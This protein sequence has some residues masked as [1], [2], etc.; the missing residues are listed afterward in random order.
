MA[1]ESSWNGSY[2]TTS[3]S[4]TF[5]FNTKGHFLD[6]NIVFSMNIPGIALKKGE[7]FYIQGEVGPRFVWTCDATTGE[8]TITGEDKT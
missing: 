1:S 2:Q 6:R 4:N 5:T 8:I 3:V 7:T